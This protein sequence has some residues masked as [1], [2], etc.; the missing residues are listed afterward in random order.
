MSTHVVTGRSNYQDQLRTEIMRLIDE[1]LVDDAITVG[2]VT[3]TVRKLFIRLVLKREYGASE[4]TRARNIVEIAPLLSAR[5][6]G[7]DETLVELYE[8]L[9]TFQSNVLPEWKQGFA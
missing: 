4:W 2:E 3:R 1:G 7:S 8:K 5:A 9:G 6:C